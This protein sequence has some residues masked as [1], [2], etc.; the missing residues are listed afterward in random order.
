MALTD[1]TIMKDATGVTIVGGTALNFKE[2]GADIKNGILVADV[3]AA[4]FSTR[5][6]VTFRN[7]EATMQSNGYYNKAKRSAVVSIPFTRADGSIA[8]NLV[9]VEMEYDPNT[10][11]VMKDELKRRGIQAVT[12]SETQNF[13]DFGALG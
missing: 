5:G 10:T 12:D 3:T 6:T 13:W 2:V 9:R 1:I 8:P 4:D 11:Q 7:R